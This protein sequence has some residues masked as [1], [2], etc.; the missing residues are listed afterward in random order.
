MTSEVDTDEQDAGGTA[1]YLVKK[2]GADIL[3]YL[4]EKGK[5][6]EIKD[7]KL[8]QALKGFPRAEPKKST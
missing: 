7:M 3:K 2:G 6:L 5:F 1:L 4:L 8:A